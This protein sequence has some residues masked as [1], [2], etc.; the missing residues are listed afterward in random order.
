MSK[1]QER[2]SITKATVRKVLPLQPRVR[3]GSPLIEDA[4]VVRFGSGC[5]PAVLRKAK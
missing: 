2:R 4:G 5:A 1:K 3:V